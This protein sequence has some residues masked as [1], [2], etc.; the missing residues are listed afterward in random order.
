MRRQLRNWLLAC[1]LTAS[2]LPVG[3]AISNISGYITQVDGDTVT[4]AEFNT[5]VGG[6]YTYINSNLTAT[7]N[8]ID[9]K[10]ELLTFDGSN[11]VALGNAGASDNGKALVLDNAETAGM[12]WASIASTTALTTKGD[13]LG[14]AAALTR[15]PVGTDGQV[16][17]ARSSNANGIA[18]ETA[19]TIPTGI[20]ALWSGAIADIPSGW[21]LCDGAGGRPNL[22]GLFVVGAGN[23]SPAATGGM[24]L[25]SPGGPYGDNSAGA[26]LGPS[27]T[28]GTAIAVT[29]APG[30][31]SALNQVSPTTITPRYYALAYI[32]K[33]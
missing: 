20:I 7:L 2:A 30:A 6:I 14:Y 22:Q 19:T 31:F 8:L 28:H 21:A 25:M 9:A 16:L 18:W 15:V 3:A 27:H 32:I 11:H 24:G 33:T 17:T 5:W 26:G 12:K 10:G 4:A 23:A 13:I 29:S 1:A